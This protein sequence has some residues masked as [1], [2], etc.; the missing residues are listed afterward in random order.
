MDALKNT[1]QVINRM[2]SDGVI[3]KYAV[4]GAIAALYYI[5]PTVTDDLDVL[6]PFDDPKGPG[7]LDVLE[8]L[9]AY[10]R[11]RGYSEFKKEGLVIEG[12]PVQFLPVVN[13]LDAEALNEATEADLEVANGKIKVSILRPE[14]IVATAL[15]LLRPKDRDRILRFVEENAVDLG[16]LRDVLKRHNLLGKWSEFCAKMGL[17][18][19]NESRLK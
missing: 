12:W 17:P 9:F 2:V 6:V 15:N 14:H 16:R 7:G 13:D 8:P 10:L 18:D 19:F 5:E 3:R 11:E 1:F 4:A